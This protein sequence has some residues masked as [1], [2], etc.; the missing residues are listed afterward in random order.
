MVRVC[1]QGN[2]R[3]THL[4]LGLMALLVAVSSSTVRA[5]EPPADTMTGVFNDRVRTLRLLLNDNMFAQPVLTIGLSQRLEFSFDVLGDDRDY[6]R[7]R[8]IHC[9]A[10]WQPDGLVDS[11]FI[12]GFNQADITDYSFSEVTTVHYV[13]YSFV[14]PNEDMRPLLSGNYLVQIYPEDDPDNVWAQARFM[15]SEQS[16]SISAAVS[17]I[18]DVDYNDAH[19]QLEIRVNV[20]QARVDDPFNNLYVVISQNGRLDNEVALRQPMT[21]IGTTSVY[22]HQ[23]GLIFDAGNEYRRFETVSTQFPAMHVSANEFHDPYYFSILQTDQPR[24]HEQYLYDST[25][26]GRFKIHEYNSAYPDTQA[27]YTVVLFTLEYPYDP[28]VAIYIDGDLTMRR[29]DS[30]SRMQY[31]SET[32]RYERALLLKQGAYNYNYLLVPRNGRRGYTS[33]IEGDKYQT[34]NEYTIKV[35][36]RRP[37]ARYDR[38]LGVST[39]LIQ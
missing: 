21:M 29:F 27:D 39:V 22:Q 19:Q 37:G 3:L 23:P 32:R 34:L 1:I 4:L 15:V 13:H 25:Q 24:A 26:A 38:L 5:A 31:N 14:L 9:N 30:N 35:Y 10:S 18:T 16:A 36:E 11:E 2:C 20:D 8:L 12:D 17:S 28:D 33:Y 7:Y 6:L